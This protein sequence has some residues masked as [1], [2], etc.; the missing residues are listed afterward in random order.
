MWKL[1]GN[2]NGSEAPVPLRHGFGHGVPLGTHSQVVAGIL[3]IAACRSHLGGYKPIEWVRPLNNQHETTRQGFLLT[4]GIPVQKL[5]NR[6]CQ[7][8]PVTE[9]EPWAKWTQ[10]EMLFVHHCWQPRDTVGR[11]SVDC[12]EASVKWLGLNSQARTDLGLHNFYDI[13]RLWDDANG[14]HVKMQPLKVER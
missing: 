13:Q 2:C 14:T 11:C 3:H 6:P 12:Q 7:L 4:S 10:R 8:C 5:L 9:P 1:P